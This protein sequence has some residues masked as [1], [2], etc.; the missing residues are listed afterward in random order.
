MKKILSLTETAM[1]DIMNRDK[2]RATILM[3]NRD[4]LAEGIVDVSKIEF[5]CGMTHDIDV[6]DGKQTKEV[7]SKFLQIMKDQNIKYEKTSN[8]YSNPE[9]FAYKAEDV[10]CLNIHFVS[11]KEIVIVAQ[12][13]YEDIIG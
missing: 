10:D 8:S 12:K 3:N 1:E 2:V 6:E 13:E 5:V 9:S 4:T 11:G 7:V